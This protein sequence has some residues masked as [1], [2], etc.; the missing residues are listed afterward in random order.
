[1]FNKRQIIQAI[2]FE[3]GALLFFIL[4]FAPLLDHSI[5]ELGVLG[6]VF[7]LLTMVLLYFY[8]QIFDSLLLKHTG[9]IEKTKLS[10]VLHALMFE[11]SLIIFSLPAV[12]WWLKISLLDALILEAAAITFMVIYTYIFHW[13]FDKLLAKKRKICEPN[14][15]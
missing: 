4:I 8:N 13:A 1:M 11:A 7:S 10:R 14:R 5:A 6:I 15:L 3:A 2:S 12:A 9:T